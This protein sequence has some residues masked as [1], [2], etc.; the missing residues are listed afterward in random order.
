MHV[1]ILVVPLALWLVHDMTQGRICCIALNLCKANIFIKLPFF[2]TRT[3]HTRIG[4]KSILAFRFVTKRHQCEHD[5][6][7]CGALC[8][9]VNR[10]QEPTVNTDYAILD[11]GPTALFVLAYSDHNFSSQSIVRCKYH[12]TII[13]ESDWHILWAA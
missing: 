12:A 3:K 1:E 10:P 7:Q 11:L 8:H 5:A 2:V 4:S 13:I 6:I 9:I